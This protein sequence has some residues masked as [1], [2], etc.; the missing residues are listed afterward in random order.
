MKR[1]VHRNGY[2]GVEGRSDPEIER[3]DLAFL[4]LPS[5]WWLQLSRS[6]GP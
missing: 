1:A 4:P 6:W 3:R 5:S 2:V